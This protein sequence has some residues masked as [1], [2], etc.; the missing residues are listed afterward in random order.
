MADQTMENR[1]YVRDVMVPEAQTIASTQTLIAARQRMQGDMNVKS[2]IVVEGDRPVGMVR[3]N[4][5]SRNETAV[6]TVGDI[7]VTDIPT[8]GADDALEDVSGV[9]SEHD[10]DRLAVVDA[11]GALTGEVPRAA[12]TLSQTT[13]AEGVTA[14]QL[15]SDA[16]SRQESP[17][18]N[19]KKDMTVVGTGGAKIGTVKEVMSDA[20][21][22]SLTH[23]VVH[24][25]LIFGKDKAVP[26]DLIDNVEGDEVCLKVDK[27]EVDVLPDI[28][29]EA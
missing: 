5:I 6:G 9:M 15:L 2:L 25:G 13:T 20:L 26:A 29:A 10:I 27:A 12:V 1:T 4:D 18:Y 24:T 28:S 21:S 11:R 7:M 3:Y 16:Q 17:V 8:I 19:V 22:G 14:G 23:V